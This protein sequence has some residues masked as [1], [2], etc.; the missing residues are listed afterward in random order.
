MVYYYIYS[1][2]N[3]SC[4]HIFL[5][6]FFVDLNWLFEVWF[7]SIGGNNF[8]YIAFMQFFKFYG[9]AQGFWIFVICILRGGIFDLIKKRFDFILIVVLIII[10]YITIQLHEKKR[11]FRWKKY[12]F[13]E[14]RFKYV[15]SHS[16][17]EERLL[18]K[19]L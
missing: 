19:Y 3:F 18:G 5:L 15:N 16:V 12:N 1:H 14:R 7:W 2:I 8:I 9:Y 4:C 11:W 10:F 13:H 6:F 17:L